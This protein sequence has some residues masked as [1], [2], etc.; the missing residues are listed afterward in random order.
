M[1]YFRVPRREIAIP[2]RETAIPRREIAIPRRGT[3]FSSSFLEFIY[4]MKRICRKS[5]RV[6]S[7]PVRGRALLRGRV[8]ARGGMGR[9][10]PKIRNYHP[11]HD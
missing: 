4:P 10:T 1:L 11:I 2:R 6:R 3:D 8:L 7:P 5:S 9:Y